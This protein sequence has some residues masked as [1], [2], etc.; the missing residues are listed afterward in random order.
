METKEGGKCVRLCRRRGGLQL[1]SLMESPRGSLADPTAASGP[2]RQIV[3]DAARRLGSWRAKMR[4]LAPKQLLTGK[5]IG[6]YNAVN[7]LL[8]LSL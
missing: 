1:S 5:V 2:G 8:V 3:N 4:K 7:H 6:R